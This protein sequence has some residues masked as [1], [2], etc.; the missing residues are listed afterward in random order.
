MGE[1]KEMTVK[2]R[3][4]RLFEHSPNRPFFRLCVADEI[5]AAVKAERERC[6][7][8]AEKT[9]SAPTWEVSYHIGGGL[10]VQ[11]HALGLAIA[12]AI[13]EGAKNG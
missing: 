13:R 3:V 1:P 5:R 8:V 7:G 4:D 10:Y 9:A 11:P 12:A 2:E 6:E